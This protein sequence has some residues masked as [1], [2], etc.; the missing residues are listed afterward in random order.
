MGQSLYTPHVLRI[1][2]STLQEDADQRPSAAELCGLIQ[3]YKTAS[4]AER[5]TA[6]AFNVD[7]FLHNRQAHAKETGT[8][9]GEQGEQGGGDNS[10]DAGSPP[11]LKDTL[12]AF[13]LTPVGI[14]LDMSLQLRRWLLDTLDLDECHC[15]HDFVAAQCELEDYDVDDALEGSRAADLQLA[16]GAASVAICAVSEAWMNSEHSIIGTPGAC[17]GED[18]IFIFC[19]PPDSE[20]ASTKYRALYEE[21]KAKSY[22]NNCFVVH[23]RAS[24]VD[25]TATFQSIVDEVVHRFKQCDRTTSINASSVVDE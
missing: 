10:D 21:T 5:A 20:L 12:I 14:A 19:E 3:S 4:R 2:H 16:S 23:P 9:V 17:A 22:G 7:S 1:L 25:R 13:S 18:P 6:R 24:Y 8:V 15:F 11:L